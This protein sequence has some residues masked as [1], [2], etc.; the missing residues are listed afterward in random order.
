MLRSRNALALCLL[1]ALTLTLSAGF[2]YAG[3]PA[4]AEAPAVAAAPTVEPAPEV[5]PEP[6]EMGKTLPPQC[7]SYCDEPYFT[8]SQCSNPYEGPGVI[9][10]CFCVDNTW[11]C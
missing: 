3:E 5:L 8:R 9:S 1:F 10:T 6:V 2:A 7:D 11:I 4:S